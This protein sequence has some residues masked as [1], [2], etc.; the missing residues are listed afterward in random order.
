M[1]TNIIINKGSYSVTIHSVELNDN[2]D[3]KLKLITPPTQKQ[4][5]ENGPKD[6]KVID[7]LMLNHTM[8]FNG[9]LKTSTDRDNLIKI[10]KGADTEGGPCS[11]TYDTYPSSPISMFPEKLTIVELPESSSSQTKYKV[12]VSLLEGVSA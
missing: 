3:N 12:Q 8:Q 7:L 6:T 9:Y 2:Y 1:T 11:I 4:I 5:Q 10:F